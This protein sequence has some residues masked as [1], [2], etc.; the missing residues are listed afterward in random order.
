M[1]LQWYDVLLFN[2][3]TTS[4]LCDITGSPHQWIWQSLRH[5][6]FDIVH[7]LAH[8]SGLSTATLLKKRF[9]WHD[10]IY[11]KMQRIQHHTN[12]GLGPLLRSKMHRYHSQCFTRWPEAAP[13]K[14]A[15][16]AACASAF[17]SPWVSQFGIHNHITFDKGTTFMLKLWTSLTCF[18]GN[19]LH[20]TTASHSESNGM[21]KRFHSP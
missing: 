17:L 7:G 8:P 3:S 13:M 12:S 21:F 18:L 16:V 2:N 19:Q 9:I 11:Q 20:H 15:S 5:H 1:S 10:I 14:D 4:I 6:I